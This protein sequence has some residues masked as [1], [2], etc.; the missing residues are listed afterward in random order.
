MSRSCLPGEISLTFKTNEYRAKKLS[1]LYL[2]GSVNDVAITM[3]LNKY[4]QRLNP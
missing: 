4:N 1:R 3:Q 2:W